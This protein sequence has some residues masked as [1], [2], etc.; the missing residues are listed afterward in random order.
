MKSSK[1]KYAY[2]II[3]ISKGSTLEM[4]GTDRKMTPDELELMRRQLNRDS[5]NQ[6]WVR[7]VGLRHNKTGVTTVFADSRTSRLP[8][9]PMFEVVSVRDL[10]DPAVSMVRHVEWHERQ[11]K[12]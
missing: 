1:F 5:G 8:A 7:S 9:E 11:H 10:C 4:F 12:A 6:Y 2:S 3:Q